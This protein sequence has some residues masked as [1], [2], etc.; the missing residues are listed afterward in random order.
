LTTAPATA[1]LDPTT[2]LDPGRRAHV[3]ARFAS[4][5]M[6]WLTTVDPSGQ[7]HSVPVWFLRRDDGTFLLYSRRS[8]AKLRTIEA[9]PKVALSLDVTDIGRDVIR[10]EGTAR[11]APELPPADQMPAYRAKYAERIG[12]L[13]G[14][15]A[16]FAE[17]FSV[18][19][20]VTPERLIA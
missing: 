14:D 9:N 13:F 3:E 6:V 2:E 10:V 15:A 7:P 8:K 16:A 11:V 20:V 5:L 1:G 19:I 18:P 17:L 4:N 12:A